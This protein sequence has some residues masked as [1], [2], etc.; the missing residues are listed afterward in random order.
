MVCMLGL[1]ILLF[2]IAAASVEV[3]PVPRGDENHTA[4]VQL[5]QASVSALEGLQRLERDLA[6][7]R[8]NLEEGERRQEI[9]HTQIN[10][11]RNFLIVPDI[12]IPVLEKGVEAVGISTAVLQTEIKRANEKEKEVR[13]AFAAVQDKIRLID[14]RIRET[15]P[16]PD[17]AGGVQNAAAELKTYR[18]VLEKQRKTLFL[19]LDAVTVQVKAASELIRDFAAV[20]TAL[21]KEIK[22]RK[23]GL[24]FQRNEIAVSTFF[25][26]TLKKE[27]AIVL[28][29]VAQMLAPESPLNR[30]DRFS[31]YA[32]LRG[33]ML[34]AGFL[35]VSFFARQG[36]SRIRRRKWYGDIRSKRAG[37]P[38]MVLESCFYLIFFIL[39][40]MVLARTSLYVVLSDGIN[41][42][43]TFL[44][45]V[46][47]TKIASDAVRIIVEERGHEIFQALLRW[48]NLFI[49]GVRLYALVYLLFYRFLSLESPL[50]I[51][52]KIISE[53]ILVAGVFRFWKTFA[54]NR[55]QEAW[56][57][58]VRGLSGWSKLVTVL[59]L[60]A[61]VAGYGHLAAWWYISWGVTIVVVCV[62]V[63][64]IYSMKDIDRK[65]KEKFEPDSRRSHGVFYPVYWVFSNG[66][67]FLIFAFTLAGIVFSWGAGER[68]FLFLWHIF[69]R[70]YTVGKIDFSLLGGSQAVLVILATYFFTGV[71][72]RLM[73]DHI[74]KESGLSTGA[75][76]SVTTITVYLIWMVGILISLSVF[77][78][79]TTSL[80]VAFGALGI[81]LGFGLQN[82]FS[83]FI[84]G[85]ILL[86]ERPIQVGDVV[87]VDG[88]W[89]EVKKIN[90][91]STLVQTYTSASLIIPNSEFISARVTNWSH[92]DSY[93]RRDLLVGV[94]YGS[95]TALV[96]SLLLKVAEKEP[97]VYSYPAKPQVHFI[98]FGESS[99]DFR[100]RFW[101]SI[102]DFIAAESRMR[103]EID[104]VFKEN[105][106]TIPFPQ[107]DIHLSR[108]R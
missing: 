40:L 75:R 48:K 86:F 87:E 99:L 27:M 44:V 92:R 84:S 82:I 73:N 47:L 21:K 59:G 57:P 18:N 17:D 63:L 64:M 88:V 30:W 1:F 23:G 78:L 41:F 91:R 79:D 20:H 90:V 61:E 102:D 49:R 103:F 56:T 85:L 5:D 106:V 71:W 93:I 46:L 16:L 97:A 89:G 58:V 69:S 65:F 2:P 6:A 67:Y 68:F 42:F 98:N 66:I 52:I 50:L 13:E 8:K 22:E 51:F 35:L 4:Q 19:L 96:E 105:G 74:L 15:V 100:L 104:R 36:L 83:N 31:S 77:G 24:L 107:R 32:N 38:L 55:S 94:A 29:T 60:F 80:T 70:T 9:Y 76:A 11:L 72:K 95:D 62:C 34:L 81:G 12:G 10:S 37:Y 26:S 25:P 43:K 7:E 108:N 45:V 54:Q 53:I 14:E 33:G 39:L 3:A 101:S 28:A